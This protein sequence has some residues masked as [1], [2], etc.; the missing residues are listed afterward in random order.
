M[1]SNTHT[2]NKTTLRDKI[3]AT[4]KKDHQIILAVF[5]ILGQSYRS[6]AGRLTSFIVLP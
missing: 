4:N 5:F 2:E 1:T 3:L 6:V